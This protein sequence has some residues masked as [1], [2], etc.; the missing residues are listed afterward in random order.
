MLLILVFYFILFFPEHFILNILSRT[1]QPLQTRLQYLFSF[2]IIN[3]L[4]YLAL[5]KYFIIFYPTLHN[6]FANS[7]IPL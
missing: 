6:C 5:H 1:I 3:V 7:V 4:S 2:S